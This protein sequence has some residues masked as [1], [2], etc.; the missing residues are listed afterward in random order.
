MI[1]ITGMHRSGTSFLAQTF[2]KAGAE[3]GPDVGLFPA[4]KWNKAGYIENIKVVDI[5]NRMILGPGAKIDFWLNAPENR[6]LRAV[7]TVRARKWRYFLHPKHKGIYERGSKL[8]SE[9]ESF[10]ADYPNIYV[11]D[12]R[13]C[14]TS[15]LWREYGKLDKIIFSIRNPAAVARSL[16]RREGMTSGLVYRNWNYHI[17][18]F[19]EHTPRDIPIMFFDFDRFQSTKDGPSEFERF[20]AHCGLTI[21]DQDLDAFQNLIRQELLTHRQTD[22]GSLPKD[23]EKLY[24]RL[25]E[26]HEAAKDGPIKLG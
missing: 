9:I 7:N 16:Q 14:L 15:R 12:P 6:I 1:I 25:I 10:T 22:S 18:S 21:S 19:L 5:N 13:F 26:L 2:Q 8:K 20:Q 23:T 17:E 24:H 11:K 4:D 3:F